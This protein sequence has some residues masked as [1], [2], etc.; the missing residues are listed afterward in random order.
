ML[1]FYFICTASAMKRVNE[2]PCI[3]CFSW[4][5]RDY[6]SKHYAH[7]HKKSFRTLY[8]C[9]YCDFVGSQLDINKHLREQHNTLSSPMNYERI[10]IPYLL[11]DQKTLIDMADAS[12]RLYVLV[13]ISTTQKSDLLNLSFMDC[14]TE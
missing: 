7:L 13:E 5:S 11:D 1:S 10:Y 2:V 9:Q 8:I 12:Q 4:F 6:L 14:L 3:L